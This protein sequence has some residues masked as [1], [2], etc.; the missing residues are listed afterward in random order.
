[1]LT[2]LLIPLRKQI[3]N[4]SDEV[5]LAFTSNGMLTKDSNGIAYVKFATLISKADEKVPGASKDTLY[6]YVVSD[7]YKTDVDGE[8]KAEYE[9]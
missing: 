4:W 9:V 3:N 7:A 5:K 2:Y 1:M 8:D 6:A